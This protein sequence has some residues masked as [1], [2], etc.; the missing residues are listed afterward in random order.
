MQLQHRPYILILIFTM[1][2]FTYIN[3]LSIGATAVAIVA[4]TF[5]ETITPCIHCVR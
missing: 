3:H 4:A 5:A 2:V 1:H